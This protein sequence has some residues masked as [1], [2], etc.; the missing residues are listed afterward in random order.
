MSWLQAHLTIAKDQVPLAELLF[1]QLGALSVTLMDAH[2]EPQLEP[3]PGETPVWTETVVTAL[4]PGEQD[5]DQLRAELQRALNAELSRRI[6][7]EVL[8]DQ[9]WERIWLEHFKPMSFGQ[10]LQVWPNGRDGEPDG[11]VILRLDPG[12]AFG[13][14]THPTTALC[15]QWLDGADLAGKTVLDYGCGSGILGVAALLLGA[16]SVLG[17]DHD[18]QAL[19]ATLQNAEVNRV[20]G[21]I[22]V[23]ET[24]PTDFQPVDLVLANILAGPLVE[25]APLLVDSLDP[26]GELVLSG[27]LAEQR[28]LV[29]AAYEPRVRFA[30]PTRLQ[31]WLRLDG[32]RC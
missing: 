3:K 4:F 16:E 24:L 5:A 18:P 21:R 14:G 1:E 26:Q 30:E 22:R 10:R 29:S 11:Q 6:R 12:L 15:L 13:T 20:A 25:L 32:H 23:A 28:D 7:L 9:V 27:I 17:V 8:E 2:D 31:D 19:R